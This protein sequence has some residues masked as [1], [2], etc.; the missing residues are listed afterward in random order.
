MLS[1]ATEKLRSRQFR[2]NE[3][4][5]GRRRTLGG[6]V[7]RPGH[8]GPTEALVVAEQPCARLI[9]AV[10][11]LSAPLTGLAD[12]DDLL[13]LLL[14]D[15]SIGQDEMPPVSDL[16]SLLELLDLGVPRR[17]EGRIL[18][19]T[20]FALALALL[21]GLLALLLFDRV[22]LALLKLRQKLAYGRVVTA[23]LLSRSVI[24]ARNRLLV[25]GD[26]GVVLYG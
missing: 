20:V 11:K 24:K 14:A 4:G 26:V 1:S 7:G 23:R 6:C 13:K 18:V 17:D 9:V 12:L 5:S 2:V 3:G 10:D 21:P 19:A 25:K 15:L 22:G 16:L 8:L